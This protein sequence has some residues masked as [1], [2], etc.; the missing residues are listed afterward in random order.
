MTAAGRALR[1]AWTWAALVSIA[2]AGA[3]AWPGSAAAGAKGPAR[4]TGQMDGSFVARGALRA[5][6]VA[7]Q[8]GPAAERHPD[9]EVA[10]TIH[11]RL[12][13]ETA[14]AATTVLLVSFRSRA[15][16][17]CLGVSVYRP[18]ASDPPEC[19]PCP[20][21]TCLFAVRGGG[22]PEA[23]R[24]VAGTI[25]PRAN[26]AVVTTR[27]G[28]VLGYRLSRTRIATPCRATPFLLRT[29]GVRRIEALRDGVRLEDV[30]FP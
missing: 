28:R 14:P 29:T 10:I 23:V 27:T 26:V 3:L 1:G 16:E 24:V 18:R 6:L 30:R 7:P 2:G 21:S 5:A 13:V 15:G 9:P 12:R 11:S 4:P 17:R 22:L 19:L 25:D 8:N 20:R